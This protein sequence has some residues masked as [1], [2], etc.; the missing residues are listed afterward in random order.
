MTRIAV[1]YYSFGGTVRRLAEAVGDGAADAGAV[2]R[3]RAVR[4]PAGDCPTCSPAPG[5][6]E[7]GVGADDQAT[8]ADLEWADG[9]AFG[10]PALFG[11]VAGALK[12]YLDSA[13]QLW[14][15]G[16]LA[17]KVVSGFTAAGSPH[18]G[19]ESTLL[20][21]YHTMFHW[22]S[23]I[24]AAGYTDPALR[25]AGGN[26]YGV[27]AAAHRDG[28]VDPAAVAAARF[29]GARLARFTARVAPPAPV[30]ADEAMAVVAR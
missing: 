29:M 7:A 25:A 10:T 17:D 11:N 8:L 4:D 15:R 21:L 23:L 16:V 24:V 19:H 18:G 30:S 22:G 2:V 14:Q 5:G 12:A 3:L 6:A 26:P 9:V 27:S 20:A 1:I 28:S 13:V